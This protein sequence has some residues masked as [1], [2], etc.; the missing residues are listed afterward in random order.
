VSHFFKQASYLQA[1]REV[2][3]KAF[4]DGKFSVLVATD[5]AARGLDIS[6]V[7]LIVQMDPPKD[8]ETYIHR[9]GRTGRAG[10]LVVLQLPQVA[11]GRICFALLQACS[12]P[13]A[14]T[15][16]HAS[17]RTRCLAAGETGVCITMVSRSKEDRVPWIE[18]KAGFTFERVGPPQ[19]KEM[20]AV[21][22]RRA[23]AA[24]GGVSD[25]VVPWFRA[26]ARECLEGQP[27]AETALAK[28]L[29][30]ITGA[31]SHRCSCCAGAAH[32]AC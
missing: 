30:K 27:D 25:A 28:A 23:A 4:K 18:K 22:A 1:Q 13:G 6:C 20:A 7:E 31:R 3:L 19:P 21:A 15:L 10:A 16:R 29:A 9:S 14:Q 24:I 12:L 17:K 26:A 8:Y 2:V 11:R 32:L 5:V